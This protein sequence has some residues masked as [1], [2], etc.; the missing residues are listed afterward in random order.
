VNRF[1]RV[2]LCAGSLVVLCVGGAEAQLAPELS[3]WLRPLPNCGTSN[4]IINN[5][6]TSPRP[7]WPGKVPWGPSGNLGPITTTP[8]PL[9]MALLGTGLMGIGLAARRRKPENGELV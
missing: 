2:V 3:N 1:G 7:N 9:T 6:P 4:C 5:I 8:E